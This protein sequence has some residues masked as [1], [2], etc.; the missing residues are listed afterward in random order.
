MVDRDPNPSCKLSTQPLAR[1]RV[2]DVGSQVYLYQDLYSPTAAG[3]G[4]KTIRL[5]NAG[6]STMLQDVCSRVYHFT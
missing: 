1:E 5:S 6:P 3:E 2:V 4:A